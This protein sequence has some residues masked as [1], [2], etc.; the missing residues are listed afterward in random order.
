MSTLQD[1]TLVYQAS[2]VLIIAAVAFIVAIVLTPLLTNILYKYK[3]GK[4]IRSEGA[5][6]FNSLHQKKQGTPTM[7]GILVW[8]TVF[9][10]MI[11]F[12]LPDFVFDSRIKT[13]DFL[14]FLTRKQTLLPLGIMIFS[15]LVGVMDDFLGVKKIGSKGGGLRIRE[16]LLLYTLVAIA[17]AW[18]FYYKLGWDILHIPGL[19]DFNIG[20]W[21]IPL[22]IIIIVAT[23]FSVNEA[24]GLDGLAGGLLGIGFGAYGAIAFAQGRYDLAI[25][26][27][28]IAGALLAFLWFNIYPARFFMGDTGTMSLG[29][30][31]G[32]IAMLTNS[33]AVLPLIGFVFVLESISVIIQVL[34]KKIRGKKIF[35]SAPLHHHFEALGWPETKVTMRFWI[36]G[37][38]T[39]ILGLAIGLI[40]KG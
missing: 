3:I 37:A 19:G 27:G 26:C 22:F 6:I 9:L 12:W 18:W 14:N 17:G 35:I 24:D 34:S 7:G 31:L 23:S 4:Q 11:I 8:L 13:F 20:I 15:A 21:Y 30:T 39:A 16:R 29:I 28:A 33:V 32:V 38:I 2:R 10:I 5:P 1:P 40:G 36:L 25:F